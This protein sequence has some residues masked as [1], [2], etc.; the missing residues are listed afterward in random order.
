MLLVENFVRPEED[1]LLDD[2]DEHEEN[3]VR[4]D[5]SG[6]EGG[7]GHDHVR[8]A[9]VAA[10]RQHDGVIPSPVDDVGRHVGSAI[11]RFETDVDARAARD[12]LG[13]IVVGGHGLRT[14]ILDSIELARLDDR[15][16]DRESAEND[17]EWRAEVL[18]VLDD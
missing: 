16:A 9:S 18:R 13:G 10:A 15:G 1:D 3:N 6:G 11:V 17:R 8:A 7:E 2:D 5:P 4:P 14:S 12:V